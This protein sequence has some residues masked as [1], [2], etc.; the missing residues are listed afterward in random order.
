MRREWFGVLAVMTTAGLL[1]CSKKE[2]PQDTKAVA[3]AVPATPTSPTPPS[4]ATGAAPA[5]VPPGSPP[6]DGKY[7]RVTVEGVT[8]PMINVMNSGAVVLVDTDG[9][10]P[11][12]WE[13]QY[14]RKRTDLA[15]GQY[16]LHK[17]DKKNNN[18]FE[19]DEIDKEGLWVI[20]PKG[21]IT[22]H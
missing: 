4:A 13:E 15:V 2:A 14:K 20:D 1:S 17:T 3:S 9:K 8:V 21:N 11:R 19:D 18:T 10:K 12:T 5:P 7:E 22:K 16:D 6:P